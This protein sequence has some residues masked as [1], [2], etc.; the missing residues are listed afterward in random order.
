MIHQNHAID[1]L[2]KFSLSQRSRVKEVFFR[3]EYMSGDAD[4]FETHDHDIDIDGLE[5]DTIDVFRPQIKEELRKLRQMRDI[6]EEYDESGYEEIVEKYGQEVADD[7][8][9]SPGDVTCYW[10]RKAQMDNI[11]LCYYDDKGNLWSSSCTY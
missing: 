2:F 11:S 6:L 7:Y 9:H 4:H 3:V 10:G 5:W 1:P 8:D